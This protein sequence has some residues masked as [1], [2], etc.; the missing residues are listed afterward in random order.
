MKY[1][2]NWK[3][4]GH[5]VVLFRLRAILEFKAILGQDRSGNEQRN[6]LWCDEGGRGSK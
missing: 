4:R 5:V 1:G 3:S 2:R 6:E